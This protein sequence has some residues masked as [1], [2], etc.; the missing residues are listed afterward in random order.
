MFLLTLIERLYS[1]SLMSHITKIVHN[2]IELSVCFICLNCS[3]NFQFKCLKSRDEY[4]KGALLSQTDLNLIISKE[5]VDCQ[6]NFWK[7]FIK[8]NKSNESGYFA[9]QLGLGFS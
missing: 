9:V 4:G 5:Y 3:A 1:Q 6:T 8:T 7:I 2:S